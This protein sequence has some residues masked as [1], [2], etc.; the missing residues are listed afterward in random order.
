MLRQSRSV[1]ART[2]RAALGLARC[3][4][5]IDA[6]RRRTRRTRPTGSS[7]TSSRRRICG[8]EIF[9]TAVNPHW[10]GQSDSLCYDWKDHTGSTFFLVVPTTKTKRPLFDQVKL[11]SQLSELSH[12]AH[13]PQN[14]PFNSLTF[15][16]DRKTFT[17]NADSSK[18]EWDV[19]TET[20]K[21]LGP[22]RT[23]AAA[24]AADAVV[25]A[26][27]VARWRQRGAPADT[28]NTCGGERRRR[29][30]RRRRRWWRR[31]GGGGGGEFRNF[32]P[33]S[34]MFAF[35]RDHNLY[36]VKVATERHGSTHARRREELQLRRA[37]HGAG[38]AAAG[39]Q[40]QQTAA[41][42]SDDEERRRRRRER[43]RIRD[44]RVRANVTWSPDSK[45]FA[46][47]RMDQRKVEA[48]VSREQHGES[49][50][51]ADG[52]HATRCRARRTS[53]RRSCTS[54]RRATPSSTPVNIKKWK[55]QRLFDLHWNGKGSDHLRMVRRDRTQRH[56]E[57][58]R[59]RA[60]DADR[61]RSCSTKT[62]TTTR[63]SARTSA[64]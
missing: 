9:T 11:A 30:R 39:A 64:T 38:A 50:S 13:D 51:R 49:A 24:V 56:F 27:A 29:A 48:A 36:V 45:A 62:S 6:R 41:T 23:P 16:K 18:W 5:R 55:D 47:T 60:A 61:S 34:S 54:A 14:L 43:R 37:R 57:L 58:D 7:P 17:F 31:R 19:A 28:V 15:S 22:L 32:S 46:V 10:L 25:A 8:R 1:R 3:S 40:R 52:V 12:H 63:A 21:R 20:L 53:A 33:D 44:P 42:T 59:H 4:A 26:A 2:I 35:A